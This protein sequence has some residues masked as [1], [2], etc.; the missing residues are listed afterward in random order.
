[1]NIFSNYIPNNYIII[2][3]KDH[4][5]ITKAIKDKTNLKNSLCMSKNVIEL[6]KLA[7]AIS[8]MISVRKYE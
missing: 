7:F 2:D 4:S 3:D 6:Q 8:E 1:M 5:W